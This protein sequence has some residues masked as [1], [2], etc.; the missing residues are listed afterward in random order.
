MDNLKEKENTNTGTIEISLYEPEV[1]FD[2]LD[3]ETIESEYQ[4]F[5]I[6]DKSATTKVSVDENFVNKERLIQLNKE[7][8]KGLIA[9]I[10]AEDF[11]YGF[12]TKA[13]VLVRSQMQF[14]AWATRNWLNDI[15]LKNWDIDNIPVLL[16]ILRIIA[17]F[18]YSEVDPEG[19]TMAGM[20][21][22]H[23]NV[24]IQECGVRAFESWGTV[25]SL[26]ILENLKAFTQ[27]LQEYID[28]VVSDLRKEYNVHTR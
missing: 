20:A 23:K 21:L 8:T 27:W 15:F 2:G 14:N 4:G 9:L 17:R 28:E 26:K 10:M 12:D 24:E 1:F 16:G 6:I 19:Q 11:E 25:E 13:D 3:V 22:S 5:S 7:L 18:D